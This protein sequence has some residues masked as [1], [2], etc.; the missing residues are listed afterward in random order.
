VVRSQACRTDAPALAEQT[1]VHRVEAELIEQLRHRR[2]RAASVSLQP[3]TIEA[4]TRPT[5]SPNGVERI[6]N[7]ST[8]TSHE[9]RLTHLSDDIAIMHASMTLTLCQLGRRTSRRNSELVRV[10]SRNASLLRELRDREYRTSGAPN[11]ARCRRTE[12]P[13][14]DRTTASDTDENQVRVDVSRNSR[15]FSRWIARSDACVNLP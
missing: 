12:N 2:L 1:G 9:T 13:P 6:I 8:L 14:S 7:E 3:T 5:I 11:Q 10:G 15:Q 4:T